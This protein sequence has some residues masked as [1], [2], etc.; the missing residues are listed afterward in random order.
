MLAILPLNQANPTA[1][2]QIQQ[3]AEQNAL[4]IVNLSTTDSQQQTEQ[5]TE[6]PK[7]HIEETPEQPLVLKKSLLLNFSMSRMGV[8]RKV[9]AKEVLEEKNIFESPNSDEIQDSLLNQSISEDSEENKTKK[10]NPKVISVSKSI[11]ESALWKQIRKR[12]GQ[13]RDEVISLCL[14]SMVKRGIFL[15]PLAN[16]EKVNDIFEKYELERKNLIEQFILEYMALT[17][18]DE[19]I[20]TL[21]A[22][23]QDLYDA[24]QYPSVDKVRAAFS[25][26]WSF[27][28]FETPQT[29]KAIRSD[30]F[31]KE[32]EKQAAQW[33]QVGE[34]VKALMRTQAAEIV[35][36]MIDRLSPDGD[37]K[38]K[39]FK[40]SFIEKAKNFLDGFDVRNITDDNELAKALA[41][42]R[43]VLAGVDPNKL[44][45]SDS[46]RKDVLDGFNKAK[47]I[48]DTMV[49]TKKRA[50][51][52]KQED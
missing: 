15:I 10:I 5:Q 43:A 36:H 12:D 21:K 46:L 18:T 16:I 24:D 7:N 25:I 37:D 47:E 27:I 11:I 39:T 49:I 8:R 26:H 42:A 19:G 17:Q 20:A 40:N 38:P 41:N 2:E 52:F 48:M 4:N 32:A 22:R 45:D 35:E 23:L 9:E 3:Q 1:L 31:K 51:S 6:Q 13:V 28:S 50:F 29:L 30:L 33:V 34:E 14:P 44:R